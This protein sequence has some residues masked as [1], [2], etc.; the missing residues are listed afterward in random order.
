V[1]VNGHTFQFNPTS[2]SKL[3]GVS[4]TVD[5]NYLVAYAQLNGGPNPNVQHLLLDSTVQ[6]AT[7][8]PYT[9]PISITDP[10]VYH[11]IAGQTATSTFILDGN[12]YLIAA[13]DTL[14][15]SEVTSAVP[16]AST[17]VMMLLGFAGVGFT[18]YRRR[19]QTIALNAA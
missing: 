4:Q 1:T 16:E 18:T 15:I 13:I 7:N 12:T 14:T 5:A 9:V 17:W 8:G 11:P 19:K 6:A 3:A 10:V 2:Y